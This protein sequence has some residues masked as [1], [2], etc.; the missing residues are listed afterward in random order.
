MCPGCAVGSVYQHPD[1]ESIARVIAHGRSAGPP[2]IVF[3]HQ[4]D[5]TNAWRDH[6]G[7]TGAYRCDLLLPDVAPGI[8]VAVE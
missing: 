2:Q 4:S 3:N 5:Q 8:R 7:L 1:N 6:T